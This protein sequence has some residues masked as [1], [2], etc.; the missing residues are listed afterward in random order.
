M[1]GA[2]RDQPDGS[3]HDRLDLDAIERTIAE[4][5]RL[6][7][8]GSRPDLADYLPPEGPARAELLP[9]LVAAEQEARRARGE[10]APWSEYRARFPE[11]G[12][13]VDS[14]GKLPGQAWLTTP[15]LDPIPES[16][17]GNP[18]LRFG[19]FEL[20]G[21]VGRGGFG[22]VY[23]A[24]DGRLDREVAL[25]VLHGGKLAGPDSRARFRRE[26]RSVARLAHPGLVPVFEV[27]VED[28]A[29]YLVS[30]FVD[31]PNLADWLSSGK[32]PAPR[33][34]ARLVAEVADALQH[35]H[36]C[37]VIHRD[38]KP[39][40]LLMGTDGRP[41]LTDFGLAR[42]DADVTLTR[43]GEAIGTPAYMSPEQARG[44]LSAIGPPCDIYGLGAVLYEL[45][46]GRPPFEGPNPVVLRQ[47][48]EDDPKPTG[49][50]VPIDLE[51]ICLTALAKEPSRRYRSADALAED[52]RRY[53]R[54]EP[55][56]ARRVGPLRRLGRRCRRRP[57]VTA[58]ALVLAA[59]VIGS[60]ATVTALWLR[61]DSYRREAVAHL[62]EVERKHR[63]A[64]E[65]LRGAYRAIW[66]QSRLAR[67]AANGSTLGVQQ[68]R[69]LSSRAI[70]DARRFIVESELSDDPTL[71]DERAAL[72]IHLAEMTSEVGSAEEAVSA[73]LDALGMTEPLARD[74]LDE[75][76]YRR[77]MTRL[78]LA[79]ADSQVEAGRLDEADEAIGRADR[80]L[81]I[82]LSTLAAP[83]HRIRDHSPGWTLEVARLGLQLAMSHDRRGRS[84]RALDLY[85]GLRGPLEQAIRDSP[86]DGEARRLLA[87]LAAELAR[88]ARNS[89]VPSAAIDD[90]RLAVASLEEAVS[91]SPLDESSR[92]EL[93]NAEFLRSELLRRAD[94]PEEARDAALLALGHF[95]GIGEA[96]PGGDPDMAVVMAHCSTLLGA[97]CYDLGRWEESLEAQLQA[98][99]WFESMPPELAGNRGHR[100]TLGTVF[101]NVGRSLHELDRLGEAEDAY[102]RAIA[103]RAETAGAD[104]SNPERVSDLGGTRHRLGLTLAAQGRATEA[105]SAF[106]EAIGHQLDALRLAPEDARFLDLLADHRA[107]L[108]EVLIRSNRTTGSDTADMGR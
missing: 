90:I 27:G 95:E 11:L 56:L 87:R 71:R 31:G 33:E 53:L 108:A 82:P 91:A 15:R 36:H 44:E 96:R 1:N 102:H 105:A 43:L 57:A 9:A 5:E 107:A 97:A 23:R 61:S 42:I 92:R 7:D 35:A 75:P 79:L 73:Y 28:G 55:V 40:N 58:L 64:V 85:R 46:T 34:A 93:A 45:L 48:L 106:K 37:G 66:Q 88:L 29:A 49:S 52:L 39:S 76:R 70:S 20:L 30:E 6:L 72:A 69:D 16:P 60:L 98:A 10:A 2:P 18:T 14:T 101:H 19:R 38:V 100:L 8:Q 99:R 17:G 103:L 63:L 3:G 59:T 89:E 25:K 77:R 13:L 67:V 51:C 41:R 62:A 83:P 4:F 22:V 21:E 12:D 32:R 80:L 54:G 78:L 65:E 24:W 26:V 68:R 50:G 86:S 104:P 94:R 84:G 47:V 74:R 81:S